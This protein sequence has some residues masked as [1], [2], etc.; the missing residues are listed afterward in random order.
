MVICHLLVNRYRIRL[1][2]REFDFVFEYLNEYLYHIDRT[3]CHLKMA[4]KLKRLSSTMF[5]Y[6][7]ERR[8]N[9]VL[10]CRYAEKTV[11]DQIKY[12]DISICF[13]FPAWHSLYNFPFF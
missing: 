6:L 3:K 9:T 7:T 1:Y 11:F 8:D 10:L 13:G 2:F 12:L 4:G 5:G